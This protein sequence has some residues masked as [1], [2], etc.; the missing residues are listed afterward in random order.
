M[1]HTLL[2]YIVFHAKH[3]I[4][5]VLFITR[6]FSTMGHYSFVAE[7]PCPT[8]KTAVAFEPRCE[9]GRVEFHY[10]DRMFVD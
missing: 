3:A 8:G 7:I 9:E 1:S 5:G 6:L 10:H 4:C 2:L